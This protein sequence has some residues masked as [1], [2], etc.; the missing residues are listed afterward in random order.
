MKKLFNGLE[1]DYLDGFQY[2]FTYTWEAPSGTITNHGMKLRIIPTSEGYY[3]SLLNI[4]VY[5]YTDHL[6][7]VR[8]SYADSDHNG[9]IRAKDMMIKHCTDMGNGN[10]ACYDEFMPGEIVSN[11]T[12]YP[13]GLLH[14]YS[15][16]T[17]NAYQNKYNGKELQ[18]T[19]MY[20][21]GAR[22]YMSDIGRWGVVDPL[23]ESSRRFTPYH[24]GNNN[25]VRFTD[26]D[27]RQS[28]DNLTTYNP[29]SAVASFMNR[30]GFG[31]DYMPMVFRDDAGMMMTSAL[32]NDGQGGGGLTATN[33]SIRAL[34]NYFD[35]NG[36]NSNSIDFLFANYKRGTVS[37][38]TDSEGAQYGQFNTLK[39]SGNWYGPGGQANWLFGAGAALSG[40]KGTLN[41]ERMYGEGIRRGLSGNYVLTG[42]NLS[43]F[44]TAPMTS[45]TVPIS[46]VG[47]WAGIA[48]KASFG[49]GVAMDGVGVY[50]YYNNPTSKNIVHP[51]KAG[52]NT[53]M[54]AYGLT[55]AGTIPAILYFGVDA[56]YPENQNGHT[57]WEAYGEDYDDL[58]RSNAAIVPGFITAP[59]GSQKF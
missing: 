30:N 25:P 2:K 32:G 51:A 29:G 39:L 42:R 38:W 11:N 26:P 15:G 13:F 17:E 3:D 6:G 19:G 55:G 8:I 46:N 47:R 58:Q 37:W 35:R 14:N 12:Y 1:T 43:Q 16:T 23:A 9:N 56:F 4:Y 7:N 41:S 40:V 5:N 49:F 45:A 28:W 20:D 53:A 50:N 10:Q 27:G 36:I 33:G 34:R 31:D 18:E 48:G 21:Y 57:G 52:L 54:G 24:Y 59:Y 22:M 44:R